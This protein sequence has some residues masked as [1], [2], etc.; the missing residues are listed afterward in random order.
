MDTSQDTLNSKQTKQK[1]A[2][3]YKETIKTQIKLT[4]LTYIQLGI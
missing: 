2:V 3:G 1:L 4:R